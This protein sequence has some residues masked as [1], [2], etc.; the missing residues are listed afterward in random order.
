MAKTGD[1]S[2][3]QSPTVKASD[4]HHLFARKACGLGGALLANT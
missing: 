2:C 3:R 1:K 4:R